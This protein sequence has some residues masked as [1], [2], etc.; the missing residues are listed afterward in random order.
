MQLTK[1]QLRFLRI[2]QQ[3]HRQPPTLG[4]LLWLGRLGWL[5]LL[6]GIAVG[7][8]FIVALP[9]SFGAT[10]Y[11]VVGMCVGAFLRDLGRSIASV[12][13]WPVIERIVEWQRVDDLA[14]GRNDRAA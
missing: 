3:L 11:L 8:W 9:S 4:S 7:V 14:Q 1:T 13:L 5:S 2:Y 6:P 10:G 12:R